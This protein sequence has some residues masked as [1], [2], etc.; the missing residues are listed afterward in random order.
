MDVDF[1]FTGYT[2]VAASQVTKTFI[3]TKIM[4]FI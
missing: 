4:L 3:K 2:N 1:D